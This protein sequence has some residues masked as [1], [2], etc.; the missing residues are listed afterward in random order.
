MRTFLL[1]KLKGHLSDARKYRNAQ[2]RGG[3][4]ELV[5]LDD[6]R[7]SAGEEGEDLD[8]E[9]DREWAQAM[10]DRALAALRTESEKK[11]QGEVYRLLRSQL[12]GDSPKN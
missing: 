4:A 11:G 7:D 9:F 1:S 2:K 10:L 8:A 3:G 12:T 6:S 5:E